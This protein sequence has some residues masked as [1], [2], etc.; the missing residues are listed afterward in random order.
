MLLSF[1]GKMF[2]WASHF[3][4][5]PPLGLFLCRV[6]PCPSAVLWVTLCPLCLCLSL[7]GYMTCRLTPNAWPWVIHRFGHSLHAHERTCMSSHWVIDVQRGLCLSSMHISH[8]KDGVTFHE[9]SDMAP[10]VKTIFLLPY[11]RP[12]LLNTLKSTKIDIGHGNLS[13]VH[14]FVHS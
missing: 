11:E 3:R 5:L 14:L 6:R 8:Q 1:S 12:H 13:H 9:F 4:G 2:S 10:A 7:S